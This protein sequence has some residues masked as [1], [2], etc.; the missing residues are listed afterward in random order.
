V[1]AS[2]LS[3]CTSSGEGFGGSVVSAGTCAS[4]VVSGETVASVV[5]SSSSPPQAISPSAAS[6]RSEDA[7]ATRIL[8]FMG[9]SFSLPRS[10]CYERPDPIAVISTFT[11]DIAY[12]R[13]PAASRASARSR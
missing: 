4:V 9:I 11:S 5:P 8:R 2:R 10:P 7:A 12:S 13:S 3:A 6:A 1:L